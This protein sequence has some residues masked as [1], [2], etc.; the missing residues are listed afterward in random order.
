MNFIQ[1][2]RLGNRCSLKIHEYMWQLHLSFIPLF[3]Y[4]FMKCT[5]DIEM[6]RNIIKSSDLL[7]HTGKCWRQAYWLMSYEVYKNLKRHF[8]FTVSRFA[9]LSQQNFS[10]W[11]LLELAQGHQTQNFQQQCN[12]PLPMQQPLW[13][14]APN[15]HQPVIEIYHD[16][17][18]E[19]IILLP[20][21]MSMLTQQA[22]KV[23]LDKQ[24]I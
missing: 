16:S 15:H 2:N 19:K 7:F 12:L 6:W 3:L 22:F 1:E 21:F 10:A 20:V 17:I 5:H 9:G 13:L 23:L 24:F 18:I 14:K 8:F 11:I 4:I